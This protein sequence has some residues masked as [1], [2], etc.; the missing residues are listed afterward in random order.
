LFRI[1]DYFAEK[2]LAVRAAVLPGHLPCISAR[3]KTG[4]HVDIEFESS[5]L[6]PRNSNAVL[7]SRQAMRANQNRKEASMKL[8]QVRNVTRLVAV[9]SL[10]CVAAWLHGQNTTSCSITGTITD[11][12]GAVVP[13]V[14]VAIT[15][16]ATGLSKT[17]TSNGAG[18]YDAESLAPGDYSVA[19]TKAGFKTEQIKNI[20][21]EPGQRRG[22]NVK[23]AIGS[24]TVSVSVE[25]DAE[26]VQTESAEAGGTITSKEVQ[27]IML[28]GRNFEALL[29]V[30]P[31]VSNVNGAN[32]SY[33]AGAGAITSYIVING[34]SDEETMYTIDGVYNVTTS[35]DITLPITP[36]VDHV[37]EMRVL[38][39]NF[40]AKYGLAGRQVLITTKSGGEQFHGSGYFFDRTN[41]Y[42]TAHGF[43]QSGQV[44]LTS[45]H[46]SDWG[47]TLGGPVEI[48]KLFTNLH[49]KLFFFVG[50]DWK[51]DHY[52]YTSGARWVFP[53]GDSLDNGVNYYNGD[54]SWGPQAVLAGGAKMNPYSSLDSVH[55]AI[56]DTRAGGGAGSGAACIYQKTAGGNYNQIL[57]KC[58]DP[59]TVALGKAYW[60]ASN[61]TSSGQNYLNDNPV[62]FSVNDE[63][64]RGDYNVNQ[65]HMITLRIM[66]E[67]ATQI[68][69]TR[70][71]ND[72]APNPNSGTDTPAG[73][74]LLRWQWTIKPTLINVASLGAVYTKYAAALIG[75]YTVPS[76]VSINQKFSGADP[77]NRIP[78][79]SMNNDSMGSESWFWMGEGALP[80]HSNNQTGEF[81]DD[82][83]WVKGNH[84][85]SG[86]LTYMWNLLHANAGTAFPMG[87][88]CIN[89]DF[90]GSAAGDF[91][92]GFL[93]NPD[94][95][96]SFG[97]EQTN[98]QRDG[99]F[100]NKWA[101]WYAEDD[102]KV[103]PRLTLNLGVRW[104]YFTAS[105]MDG[106][107]IANFVPS[108]FTT[109][110]AP[111]LCQIT[112]NCAKSTFGL[113]TS[114]AYLNSQNQPLV[115]AGGAA[116]NLTNNGML[117]AGSG[118]PDGFT[119][120]KKGL[121][122]PRIGF[123]YR[124]TNDGKTSLHGGFGMGYTQVGLMQSSNLLA[125][126]PFV[127]QPTYNATEFTNPAGSGSGSIP[128]APGLT[129]L[130]ATSPN[131]RPASIRNYSLTIE[132]E[133]LPGG[134][135][136]VGYAGMVT[137]HIFTTG[138]D[139][140]FY[141]N[142]TSSG[143][144]A[145][146][147][148]GEAEATSG[149]YGIW[150]QPGSGFQYDPCINAA[151][152]VTINGTPYT[153][154]P[155][156]SNYYRPYA[157]YGTISTGVSFGV[158]NY[159]GLLVGYVQKMRDLTTHVS[160]TFSKALGDV[161]ASGT[162]V[163]YSSSG[164]F[165]NSDN[166]MGDYGRP[167]YDR[168]NVFVYSVVY[169]VPVP[170]WANNLLGKE[171][172]GGWSF[173]SYGVVESGFAQTPT[174]SSGLA[175]RPNAAGRLVR[176]HG[177]DGKPGQAP[178]YS[179]Q[180]FTHPAWGYFG[181]ASV[182]SLRDPKEVA[183]HMSVEKGFAVREWANIKLGAQAFNV[184]NHPNVM[185]INSGWSPTS[186]GTFGMATAYG[187]PRQMQFYTKI[188][189]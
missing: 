9:F 59:N 64:Y 60:P 54:L 138:W 107:Q 180:N 51:A 135:V 28:N 183:F 39:D 164:A 80:T 78:D 133:V 182:G 102:W 149:N 13:A 187:D 169:T 104:S 189:F 36:V 146:I 157:G 27:N 179:F 91:L 154:T 99:R 118:T 184:F 120:P 62:K 34:S 41:E 6:F 94:N 69:A 96:C 50:A 124:L 55:Q 185:T 119:T 98:A 11:A 10:L 89:G 25:A 23:L 136:S 97:Y 144:A 145:C 79:I 126:I 147:A 106:N 173:N 112:A 87:N 7:S 128:N 4:F 127:Q 29:T 137:Q 14:Q 161:N 186:Q 67:E 46:L 163:A 122:A 108:A 166:P 176:N 15:N 31:G 66:H 141:L 101:E 132:K 93:A 143:D 111:A 170:G 33:Q 152:S 95:S 56:L 63:L 116:A 86:G 168:P 53:T 171:L 2:L 84:V 121:F 72:Y 85:V 73:N 150:T 45:L 65:N 47:I 160:Y 17:E 32:G 42:G 26:V 159:N 158:A 162:Q 142:G 49:R 181:T 172:L 148:Q 82:I 12:T 20:H 76:G 37:A 174:Y 44:P 177:T 58:M 77:L 110:N 57:P 52:A 100:R 105:A 68:N 16:Q 74:M 155:V 18:F 140:N 115:S 88:F 30:V 92:L 1:A 153:A 125:N 71:Y 35:S 129:S 81:S 139:A 151:G 3:R 165:Q 21:L 24:E 175:S 188:T 113:T 103:N 114:W 40:S 8:N 109:S 167:D 83:S 156:I 134:V 19:T 90:S 123:A 61:Y 131:Y 70:G 178:L 48:P 5:L 117:T 130:S 75:Q 38:S 22:L 43:L